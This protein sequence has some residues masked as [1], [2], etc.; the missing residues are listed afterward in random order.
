MELCAKFWKVTKW[1]YLLEQVSK[2]ASWNWSEKFR[3]CKLKL[4]PLRR[5]AFS[6]AIQSVPPAS[7]GGLITQGPADHHPVRL[8]HSRLPMQGCVHSIGN[9]C[10]LYLPRG[11]TTHAKCHLL[12]CAASRSS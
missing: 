10:S 11:C 6:K 12:A 8:Q 5:S 3:I 9:V 2:S 1:R 4:R 7:A